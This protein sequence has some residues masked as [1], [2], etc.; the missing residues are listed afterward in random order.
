MSGPCTPGFF[1]SYVA[2]AACIA[3][4]TPDSAIPSSDL[5]LAIIPFHS[6]VLLFCENLTLGMLTGS[7]GLSGLNYS[8]SSVYFVIFIHTFLRRVKCVVF[9]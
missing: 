3:Y 7:V 2:V 9:W 5:I 4:S 6:R 8:F 1:A